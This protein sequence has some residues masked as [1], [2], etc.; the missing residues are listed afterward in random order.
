MNLAVLV[1]SYVSAWI[2]CRSPR[3]LKKITYAFDEEDVIEK[4]TCMF[5]KLEFFV[6]QV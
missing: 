3:S 6:P 1:A 5:F 2:L 4:K